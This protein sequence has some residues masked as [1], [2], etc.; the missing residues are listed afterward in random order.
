VVAYGAFFQ[1]ISFGEL[2]K[3]HHRIFGWSDPA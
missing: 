3:S 2:A 1:P